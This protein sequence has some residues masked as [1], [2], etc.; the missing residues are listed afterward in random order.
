[1]QEPLEQLYQLEDLVD[2]LTQQLEYYTGLMNRAME[3]KNYLSVFKNAAM[4]FK[5]RFKK[6]MYYEID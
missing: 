3:A 1:M 2:G 5:L 6:G 4:V